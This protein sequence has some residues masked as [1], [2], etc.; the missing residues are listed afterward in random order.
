MK[1]TF[2]LKNTLFIAGIIAFGIGVAELFFPIRFHAGS[3]IAL[4]DNVN[5]LNEMRAPGGTMLVMGIII[6]LG[7]FSS[8]FRV[9]S[10]V[11]ATVLYLAYG[12]SRLYSI[13]VD[14][15]PDTLLV[16]ATALEIAIGLICALAL[17]KARF[18]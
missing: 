14:G 1:H 15:M 6:L 5:L 7:A 16:Q 12:L 18:S 3:G 17:A 9:S 8:A 4:G 2:I 13:A 10:A 11:L